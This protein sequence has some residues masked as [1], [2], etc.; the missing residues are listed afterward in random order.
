TAA[1]YAAVI[2]RLV[3]RDHTFG[4]GKSPF[5]HVYVVDGAV[6]MAGH[7]MKA[8]KLGAPFAHSAKGAIR[9]RLRSLPPIDF[10]RDPDSV[11]SG[12]GEVENNGVIITL[13]PIPSGRNKVEVENNLWCGGLCAQWLTYVLERQEEKWRITG[14]TGPYAIS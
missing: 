2:H 8:G 10:V 4:G 3:S 1:I 6:A 7:V 11:R 14:T 9:R 5:E 13:G 12:V